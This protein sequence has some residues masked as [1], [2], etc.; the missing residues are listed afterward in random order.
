MKNYLNNILIYLAALLGIVAFVTLFATPLQSYNEI[1]GTWTSYNVKAYLGETS[2]GVKVYNGSFLPV[3]GF[4]VPFLMSIF[5]II[6][7]FKPELG[8][9][10]AAINTIFAILYFFSAVLV[11]LT[12]EMFLAV[13]N[14]GETTFIRNGAGPISSAVCSFSAGIILL[15]VAWMPGRKKDID[16]IE[17]V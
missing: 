10:L 7:S 5:L 9:R 14:F 4:I 1:Q 12:K 15:F 2:A 16:F 17:K 11:L 6:E 3:I 13:N 8:G